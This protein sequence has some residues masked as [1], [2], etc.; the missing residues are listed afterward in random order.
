MDGSHQ[1]GVQSV[2]E[3]LLPV[4]GAARRARDLS[5]MACLGWELPRLVPTA[6]QVASELVSNAVVHAGTMIDLLLV[7]RPSGLVIF[8]SDGS[9]APAVMGPVPAGPGGRGLRI[10]DALASQWG[11]RQGSGGK[12]VWAALRTDP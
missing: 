12:L 8:V 5:T 3:V 7:R 1:G 6:A 2:R 11:C 4:T 9:A 10:V